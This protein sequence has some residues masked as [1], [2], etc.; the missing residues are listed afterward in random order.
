M[1]IIDRMMSILDVFI[2]HEP[3][4]F[5]T[6]TDL[7]KECGIPVSSMHR[8]L[9]AMIE[10][11]MIVQDND[12]KMYGLGSLWL[13]YGLKVYD[14]M[15]YVSV[16]RPELEQLMREV[17]ASVYLS[18]PIE[19]ES[20]IIE[21]IDCISQTIRAHDRL[22]LRTPLYRGKTNLVMLAHMPIH[23]KEDIIQKYIPESEQS[24]F[25]KN[26]E[27]I[28]YEGF[29]IER[30]DTTNLT[31]IASPIINYSGNTV[32]AL[33]IKIDRAILTVEK[34]KKTIQK[35]MNVANKISWK[36]GFQHQLQ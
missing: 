5:Y 31:T 8:I 13:E 4:R 17:Q 24:V 20:I 16:I 30:N 6:L 21:R 22:G 36:M 12:K 11:R 18:K 7:S 14:T 23:K 26:L 19:M 15:D 3:N 1:K 29:A 10:H 9:T 34:E 27:E 2:S 33:H 25:K 28:K 35:V 32:A